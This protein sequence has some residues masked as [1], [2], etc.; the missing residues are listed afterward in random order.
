MNWSVFTLLYEGDKQILAKTMNMAHIHMSAYE[1]KQ[2]DWFGLW[3]KW[4]GMWL[5]KVLRFILVLQAL[6]SIHTRFS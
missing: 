5:K 4:R 3:S 2:L 6:W 1:N